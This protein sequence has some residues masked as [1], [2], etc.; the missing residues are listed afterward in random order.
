[1]EYLDELFILLLVLQGVYNL[2][3]KVTGG[4]A[5]EQAE[6]M[7]PPEEDD[8]TWSLML[9]RAREQ[10]R[11]AQQQLVRNLLRARRVAEGLTGPR[12]E[13]LR[14][15]IDQRVRP[16]MLEIGAELEALEAHFGPAE[17]DDPD[18]EEAARR[19]AEWSARADDLRRLLTR[20]ARLME[21]LGAIEN[22]ARWRSD[23]RLG[24]I[25]GDID[26]VADSMLAPLAAG[27]RLD[28]VAWPEGPP[29][30][31]PAVSDPD[32]LRALLD[33][34]PLVFVDSDV[35]DE[36]DRWPRV[37]Q[38]V[39]RAVIATLP[40]VLAPLRR[41]LDP[42]VPAW[43]PRQQGRQIV[44]DPQA[45]AARWLDA[46]AVDA[47]AALMMGPVALA[48]LVEH[49]ARPED[50]YAVVRARAGRDHRTVGRTPPDHLRV[51]AMAAVLTR[52]GYDVEA[53]D[54]R[55]RWDA[56]HGEPEALILPSLFGPAVGLPLERALEPLRA[57]LMA[58]V[59]D[60]HAALGDR[61]FSGLGHFEMSPGLWAR[62]RQRAESVAAGRAFSDAPR[63]VVAAALI[64]AE[65]QGAFDHRLDRAV[66]R[67]I[68]Q[69]G[70]RLPSDPHYRPR[71][72]DLG[73]PLTAR[74]L[75]D[76]IVLRS[77]LHRPHGAR[78]RRKL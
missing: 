42:G 51:A 60:R 39:A 6:N 4:N 36:Q 65:R 11:S 78:A 16:A 26:V 54:L 47:L 66:H 61:S 69:P 50:P 68:T 35:V 22:G 9:G 67:L 2:Y 34:H 32:T 29:L 21:A 45:A 33:G 15:A 77:A 41:A 75:I 37:I 44:F 63:I 27:G 53:R 8:G 30:T 46:L 28:R 48:A 71:R 1:M 52:M 14:R 12:V 59:A 13:P 3:Q 76:A 70:E 10:V 24:E 74:D 17:G 73:D 43:L 18:D 72:V 7:P 56:L 25:L 38:A 64:A 40:G 31:L 62:A 57:P 20:S 55:Q 23:P 58:L 19:M 5:A 49:L